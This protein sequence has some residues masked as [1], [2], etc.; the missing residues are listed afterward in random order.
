MTVDELR[1]ELQDQPGDNLVVIS[2]PYGYRDCATVFHG[3]REHDGVRH[4]EIMADGDES[5]IPTTF[6]YPE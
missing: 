5:G 3:F 4:Y 6:I 1:K 2:T